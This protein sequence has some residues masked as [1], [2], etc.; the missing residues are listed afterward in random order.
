[1]VKFPDPAKRSASGS[2]TLGGGRG[3][4]VEECLYYL[5]LTEVHMSVTSLRYWWNEIELKDLFS[6]N[7][8]NKIYVLYI[9]VIISHLPLQTFHCYFI[10]FYVIVTIL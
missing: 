9:Y 2:A 10:N 8:L 1:M 4:A 3:V 5:D 7:N 6:F